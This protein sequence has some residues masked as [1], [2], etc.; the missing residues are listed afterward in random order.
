L[1]TNVLETS[2]YGGFN[3]SLRDIEL[4]LLRFLPRAREL[5]AVYDPFVDDAVQAARC[6]TSVRIVA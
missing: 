2:R 3:N 4:H 1:F 5:M 6:K